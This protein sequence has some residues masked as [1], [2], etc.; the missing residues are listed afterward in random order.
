MR[1]AWT[2][3]GVDATAGVE[4]HVLA[5]PQVMSQPLWRQSD[6]GS[7]LVVGGQQ[8]APAPSIGVDL[9]VFTSTGSRAATR[10]L[11]NML[12][13]ASNTFGVSL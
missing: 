2:A 10:R 1:G 11:P 9:G 8:A 4:I 12:R 13:I 3:Q 7:G 6:A 5:S